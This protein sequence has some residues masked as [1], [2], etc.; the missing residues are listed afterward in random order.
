MPSPTA[1]TD[2]PSERR[3]RSTEADAAVGGSAS[4]TW[5][6]GGAHADP[7]VDG[8]ED[9]PPG[10]AAGSIASQLLAFRRRVTIG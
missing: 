7:I 6:F 3:L 5:S 2:T 4:R 9:A 1:L 8:Y 10:G